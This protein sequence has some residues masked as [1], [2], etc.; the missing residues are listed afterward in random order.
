M[1]NKTYVEE[2]VNKWVITGVTHCE[3]VCAKPDHVD[4]PVPETDIYNVLH[5]LNKCS[6]NQCV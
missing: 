6:R 3:P 5:V 2:T 4:M 1:I